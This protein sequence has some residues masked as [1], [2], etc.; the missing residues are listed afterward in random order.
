M[1]TIF[2]VI[3][4]GSV[5]KRTDKH[6]LD[7]TVKVN[8]VPGKK[9]ILV[10]DRAT[11]TYVASTF[12]DATTGEWRISGIE[13]FPAEKLLVLAFDDSGTF[14]AEVADFVSQKTSS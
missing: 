4:S 14:N 13:E 7:G 6:Y 3:V 2:G 8:G 1:T 9:R 10:V 11:M 5:P 12:S